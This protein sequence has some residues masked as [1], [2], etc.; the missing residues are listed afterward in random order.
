MG[1]QCTFSYSD[2]TD[3]AIPHHIEHD[4]DCDIKTV[5]IT[6]VDPYSNQHHQF[7]LSGDSCWFDVGSVSLNQTEAILW[8]I[9]NRIC[10]TC[11]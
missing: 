4:T 6:R 5:T 1:M 7:T 11:A 9:R 3:N 10:F 8:L 2:L